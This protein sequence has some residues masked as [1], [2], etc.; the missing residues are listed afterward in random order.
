MTTN[1]LPTKSWRYYLPRTTEPVRDSWSL[2]F[3]DGLCAMSVISDHGVWGHMW[4]PDGSR[5]LDFRRRVLE[6]EGEYVARKF[7]YH[8]GSVFDSDRA[9]S[10][11]QEMISDRVKAGSLDDEVARVDRRDSEAINDALSFQDFLNRRPG[12]WNE[13]LDCT[14]MRPYNNEGL[15]QWAAVSFPRLQQLIRAQLALEPHVHPERGC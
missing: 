1:P 12:R 3:L 14:S 9:R 11:V 6:F 10:L 7:A 4:G 13:Y 5:E 8:A 15:R 2:V